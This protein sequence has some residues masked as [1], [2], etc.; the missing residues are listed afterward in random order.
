MTQPGDWR[1]ETR[2][3]VK[4]V[5]EDP[6]VKSMLGRSNMTPPQF[7]TLL[8][9]Q[10]GQ[11]M[12]NKRLTRNEMAQI[13]RKRRGISRG[14]FNR[15]LRQA[16]EN[17][18]EAIHTVLLLGYSELF[19][20]PSLVP[21]VDASEQLRRQVTEL[22]G[23]SEQEPDSYRASVEKLLENLEEA[24]EALYGRTRDA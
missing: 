2:G 20:S 3:S 21:F 14:A 16:R 1:E 7:E 10:L 24:F 19:E 12:A 13:A 23:S 9:D 17:V 22:R 6:V 8:M 15:T 5:L 11:D 4:K 18:S